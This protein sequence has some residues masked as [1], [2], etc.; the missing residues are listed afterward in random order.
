MTASD[1]PAQ[2]AK[3]PLPRIKMNI[4]RQYV[5]DMSFENIIAR[6]KSNTGAQAPNMQL[7][8]ALDSHKRAA[9]HEYEVS[10]KLTVDA[11]TQQSKE[12]IFLLEIEY[13]GLFR[14]EGL[15]E[16]DQQPFLMSECPRHI[17]PYLC[18]IISDITRD[19]GFTPLMLE[20]VDFAALYRQ[21]LARHQAQRTQAQAANGASGANGADPMSAPAK[22]S[23]G[24]N[25]PPET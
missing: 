16:A 12:Q 21:S 15:A 2:P 19:G 13:V 24:E 22:G 25:K 6:N 17:Y 3:S 18:R 9:N 7:S 20:P 4:L 11:K 5:R 10:I 8:V 1:S 14:I 23:Q